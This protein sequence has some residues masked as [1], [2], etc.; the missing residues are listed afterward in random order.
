MHLRCMSASRWL[1]M[2]VSVSSVY[3]ANRREQLYIFGL[4]CLAYRMRFELLSP[5]SLG[6]R[7]KGKSTATSFGVH[8]P[9]R[10]RY[11]AAVSEKVNTGPEV[12]VY[13]GQG[14]FALS[15]RNVLHARLGSCA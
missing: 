2:S 15:K 11:F 13:N 4:P 14:S 6:E 7:V 1:G 5:R 9:Y 12:A 10:V 3:L 8:H